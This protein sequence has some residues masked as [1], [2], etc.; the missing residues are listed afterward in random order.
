MDV[1]RLTFP[2]PW[3]GPLQLRARVERTITPPVLWCQ[4]SQPRSL[5]EARDAL[6]LL[7][8]LAQ[9]DREAWKYAVTV[10]CQAQDFPAGVD[11]A[12]FV[13]GTSRWKRDKFMGFFDEIDSPLTPEFVNAVEQ[14]IR[15]GDRRMNESIPIEWDVPIHVEACND[16]S[17]DALED[18]YSRRRS[19]RF[20][21]SER[22]GARIRCA[23]VI[24]STRV[25]IPARG[26][27]TTL[28]KARQIEQ[29]VACGHGL[30]IFTLWY[31]YKGIEASTPQ[32][33]VS[34]A[35]TYEHTFNVGDRLSSEYAALCNVRISVNSELSSHFERLL[36]AVAASQVTQSVEFSFISTRQIP[37]AI[38]ESI[39]LVMSSAYIYEHASIRNVTL[40]NVRLNSNAVD[41]MDGVLTA[42]DPTRILFDRVRLLEVL[43]MTPLDAS[44]T[45]RQGI[46]E[47]GAIVRP[48]AV[49]SGEVISP[50]STWTLARDISN[51]LVLGGNDSSKDV[52]AILPGFGAY[53][54]PSSSLT[55]SCDV[56][57]Y[58]RPDPRRDLKSIQLQFDESPD[59]FEGLPRFLTLTGASLTRL[60]L[61]F[62]SSTILDVG[63]ILPCCPHLNSLSVFGAQINASDFV[64][65]ARD[66]NLPL[67]HLNT[68]LCNAIALV[69]ALSDSTSN[70]A[71]T[72]RELDTDFVDYNGDE[73]PIAAMLSRNHTL[74]H[75]NVGLPRDAYFLV[76]DLEHTY[77]GQLLPNAGNRI[78]L[79]S[80]LAF[81]SIFVGNEGIALTT[82]LSNKRRQATSGT[83]T[84]VNASLCPDRSILKMIFAFAA[85]PTRRQVRF[86][87]AMEV[88]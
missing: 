68:K 77:N 3:C 73:A 31:N 83:T 7:A 1:L 32:D 20:P 4:V 39:A 50:D 6:L 54:A 75:V 81:L 64:H 24:H 17:V 52:V 53:L 15:L 16:W 71:K 12:V 78:P 80:R 47:K 70:L 8:L 14:I 28:D 84:L 11:D 72:L 79:R 23:V 42:G 85:P 55:Y 44:A 56:R 38:Y 76:R 74:E 10:Y 13:V 82:T 61:N 57:Y 18:L 43:N 67:T 65:A 69:E 48:L 59:A 58:E 21:V 45:I 63:I 41:A 34:W 35:H 27:C 86:T 37:S 66:L 62:R 33:L 36:N 5:R 60:T 26:G 46:V 30:T 49:I 87:K 88:S 25:I 29:F 2:R 19:W 22:D 51:V 9:V 40:T